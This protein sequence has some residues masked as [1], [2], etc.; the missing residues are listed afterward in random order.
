MI[1]DAPGG[2]VITIRVIPR[3]PRTIIG[4]TRNNALLVRLA[5]A[6]IDGAAN[7]ELIA[8]LAERLRI[9]LR[10]VRVISGEKSR[11]KKVMVAGLSAADVRSRIE[12]HDG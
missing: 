4:G 5:A 3:A 8:S 7:A 9:P 11:N 12:S 1:E 6:P 10:N 2:A